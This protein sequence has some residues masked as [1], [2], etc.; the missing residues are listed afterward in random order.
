MHSG[1]WPDQTRQHAGHLSFWFKSF[2]AIPLQRLALATS[3]DGRFVGGDLLAA[4]ALLVGKTGRYA[5]YGQVLSF[6]HFA[7]SSLGRV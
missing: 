7:F 4:S 6:V 5:W 3:S 2:Q 1:S